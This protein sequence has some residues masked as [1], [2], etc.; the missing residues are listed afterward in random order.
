MLFVQD[1]PSLL[2]SWKL[3]FS[4]FF[5]TSVKVTIRELVDVHI[6]DQVLDTPFA[7]IRHWQFDVQREERVLKH[8]HPYK[9][10]FVLC[11]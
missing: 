1:A 5:I 11:Y 3:D 6:C 10:P 4:F 7:M 2:T 9:V 8:D